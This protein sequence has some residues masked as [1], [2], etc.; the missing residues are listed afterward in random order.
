MVIPI[1]ND[2]IAE[3]RESFI[4]ILQEGIVNSVQVVFPCQVTIE[5]RDDDGEHM[6]ACVVTSKVTMIAYIYN[7]FLF[8]FLPS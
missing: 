4:C 3:P 6:H 2:D 7:R 5:I 8:L 1:V